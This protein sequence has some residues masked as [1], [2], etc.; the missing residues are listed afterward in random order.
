MIKNR[1]GINPDDLSFAKSN[2]SNAAHSVLS[3]WLDTTAGGYAERMDI[4]FRALIKAHKEISE[5]SSG[6]TD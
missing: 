4:A 2:I 3:A 1:H 5:V 6:I